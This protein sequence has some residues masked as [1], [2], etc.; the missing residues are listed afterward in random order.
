MRRD[1]HDAAAFTIEP[2]ALTLSPPKNIQTA[3][4]DGRNQTPN[5]LK[6]TNVPQLPA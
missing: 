5:R 4:V 6:I 2:S 1:R 3:I